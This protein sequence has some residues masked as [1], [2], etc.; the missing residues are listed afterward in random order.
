M[1]PATGRSQR[2]DFVRATDR[3]RLGLGVPWHRLMF[4]DRRRTAGRRMAGDDCGRVRDVAA[5]RTRTAT[6]AWL[7]YDDK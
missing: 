6:S 1:A 2:Y 4:R 5:D 7:R 3:R